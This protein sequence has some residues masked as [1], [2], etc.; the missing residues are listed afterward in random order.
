MDAAIGIDATDE[1]LVGRTLAINFTSIH[2]T[3]IVN[4]VGTLT[5]DLYP[6]DI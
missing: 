3:S 5:I 2:T 1:Y 6:C 4:P